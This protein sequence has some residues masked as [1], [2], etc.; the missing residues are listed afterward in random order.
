MSEYKFDFVT[1]KV[2]HIRTSLPGIYFLI[3]DEKVLHIG[4][5][6]DIKR[7]ILKHIKKGKEFN[8]VGI[9][10]FEGKG[11]QRKKYTQELIQSIK[12]DGQIP[13]AP[14][15][16]PPEEPFES[17]KKP[18]VQFGRR[19]GR[20]QKSPK[21]FSLPPEHFEQIRPSNN[22]SL[23]LTKATEQLIDQLSEQGLGAR[24]D[25]VQ[26][27]I[28]QL[29]KTKL[30]QKPTQAENAPPV[31]PV[32]EPASADPTDTQ[33]MTNEA[34]EALS[35]WTRKV[36][37]EAM[38]EI[39]VELETKPVQESAPKLPDWLYDLADEPIEEISPDIQQP[40]TNIQQTSE[41][42]LPAW[43]HPESKTPPT[44]PP[45]KADQ[46]QIDEPNIPEW[47]KDINYKPSSGNSPPP[48]G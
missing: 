15:P 47:M 7:E 19:K 13:P 34:K 44:P 27:A 43:T 22:G 48:F 8:K 5:S 9:Q 28:E 11:T 35:A 33:A 3:L 1:E 16:A 4:E 12:S 2:D 38:S 25:I 18:R 30:G 14:E 29:H 39:S 41:D 6:N 31:T 26:L 32:A 42:G 21:E 20:K 45:P 37:Q 46:N 24:S 40:K 17:K 10:L 36:T 23:K